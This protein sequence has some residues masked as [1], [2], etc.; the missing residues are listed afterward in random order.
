MERQGPLKVPTC[1]AFHADP[2]LSCGSASSLPAAQLHSPS[3]DLEGEITGLFVSDFTGLCAGEAGADFTG[4]PGSSA[5]VSFSPEN[6]ENHLR[7]GVKQSKGGQREN[8]KK[9]MLSSS[10]SP[11][12]LAEVS[13][14]PQTF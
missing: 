14:F 10:W 7:I 5:G 11:F 3:K 12:L 13:C 1:P 8:M 6:K 4:E 2:F 9:K